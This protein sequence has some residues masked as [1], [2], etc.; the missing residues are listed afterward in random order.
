MPRSQ[1]HPRA[2]SAAPSSL[3]M[4]SPTEPRAVTT[5]ELRAE[6]WSK[7]RIARAVDRGELLHLHRDAYCAPDLP[8]PCI[9]AGRLGARLTCT[10]ELERLGVFVMTHPDRVHVHLPRSAALRNP[11][12]A[13]AK[14]HWMILNRPRPRGSLCVSP[15]DAL[16]HAVGCQEP[17][18]AVASLDSALHRRVL[19][20]SELD[21]LFAALPARHGV[22]RRLLDERAESG[23]ESLLRLILRSIGCRYDVQVTIAGVGRV[24]F[25]VNGWLIVE[26][27]SREFH[28]DWA[29]QRRDHVRDLASAALGFA[30]L[31]VTAEDIMWRPDEVRRALTGLL[32]SPGGRRGPIAG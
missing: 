8:L 23:P 32:R 5:S 17:R 27:D 22:L 29:A 12:S 6:G 18:A 4:L 25:V 24:D 9:E 1:T 16:I 20:G 19:R 10:S 2:G 11:Q 28:G 14:R 7:R 13:R 30:T 3:P 31:R 26:C 15:L 21:E